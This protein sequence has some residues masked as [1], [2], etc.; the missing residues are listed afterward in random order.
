V[1]VYIEYSNKL[2]YEG[3]NKFESSILGT[4]IMRP[5]DQDKACQ[6]QILELDQFCKDTCQSPYTFNIYEDGLRHSMRVRL[7]SKR[8]L[9]MLKLKYGER[10]S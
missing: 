1:I 4:L 7:S 10:C 6:K 2:Q 9:F 5:S 8:D 3:Y